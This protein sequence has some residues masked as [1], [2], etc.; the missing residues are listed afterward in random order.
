MAAVAARC[1]LFPLQNACMMRGERQRAAKGLSCPHAHARCCLTPIRTH[2]YTHHGEQVAH[3]HDRQVAHSC[4]AP[5]APEL[6]ERHKG[7]GD[8]A[9]LDTW[10]YI[11]C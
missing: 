8:A 10:G 3:I 6:R 2:T 4:T 1:L 7:G 5:L 11:A 9:Q